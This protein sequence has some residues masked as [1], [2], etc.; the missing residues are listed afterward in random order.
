MQITRET[1][2]RRLVVYLHHEISF[3]NVVEWAQFAMA[4]PE[5]HR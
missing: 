3:D 4:A 5:V 1:V 2:A